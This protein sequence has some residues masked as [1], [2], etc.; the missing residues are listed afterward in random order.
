MKQREAV[1]TMPHLES[2][3]IELANQT[4]RHFQATMSWD[5]LL[6]RNRIW[7]RWDGSHW[8]SQEHLKFSLNHMQPMTLFFLVQPD[9]VAQA[10]V[11]YLG[12]QSQCHLNQSLSASEI[13]T[14]KTMGRRIG[15]QAA[16]WDA[17]GT[18]APGTGSVW[19]P[20]RGRCKDLGT[21]CFEGGTLN[22]EEASELLLE[23]RVKCPW[24]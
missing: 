19:R 17:C 13:L 4:K 5:N 14:P 24:V 18:G 7:H 16:P 9:D 21:F 1:P 12:P 2:W 6:V 22:H 15:R 11:G 10:P 23:T 8:L 3:S 20:Q